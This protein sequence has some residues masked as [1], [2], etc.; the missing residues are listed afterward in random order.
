[1]PAADYDQAMPLN[2]DEEALHRMGLQISTS[3]SFDDPWSQ[4]TTADQCPYT[5]R[6]ECGP[7][8]VGRKSSDATPSLS[9]LPSGKSN[10]SS[11][12]HSIAQAVSRAFGVAMSTEA[13]EIA[14]GASAVS[15]F[16]GGFEERRSDRGR[17]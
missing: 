9:V 17:G 16:R 5:R 2:I 14:H 15:L 10:V 8:R 13:G 11:Q 12:N 6:L 1:M 7:R 3:Q 4:A